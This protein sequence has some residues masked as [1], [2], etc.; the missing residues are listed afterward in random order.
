MAGDSLCKACNM[1]WREKE[2]ILKYE[3]AWRGI[4]KGNQNRSLGENKE[5]EGVEREEERVRVERL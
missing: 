5:I 1:Q 4:I 3:V 2:G